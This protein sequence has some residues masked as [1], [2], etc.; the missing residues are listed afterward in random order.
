[1]ALYPKSYVFPLALTD[2][3]KQQ[4]TTKTREKLTEML[5]VEVD[6]VMAEYV[7]VMVGNK[8]NMEQ[9]AHDL[10]DFI[11]E[12]SADQFAAWLSLLLPTFEAQAPEAVD[13]TEQPQA[14]EEASVEEKQ[15]D[16]EAPPK[17]VVSLKGLSSS[18]S[19]PSKTKTVSLSSNRGTIRS[20]NPSKTDTDDVI[21]R[22]AQRFGIVEKKP[23][24]KKSPSSASGKEDRRQRDESRSTGSK[25]RASERESGNR[26]SQRLGPP[27]NVD[28]AELDARDTMGSHKKRRND[29]DRDHDRDRDR[30][31]ENQRG[32][33][34]NN[35]R[36]DRDRDHDMEDAG[37]GGRKRNSD[38][39]DVQP[40]LPPSDDKGDKRDYGR[41]MGPLMG[42]Q[43]GPMGYGGFPPPYGG[44]MF[45]PPPGY[46]PMNP[47]AM[48]FPPQGMPPYGGRGYP[49]GPA[50]GM[51]NGP[52]GARPFQNRKWVN[53]N[54]AKAEE[55]KANEGK[56]GSDAAEGEGS[57][58]T[59]NAGLNAGAPAFAPRNPFFSSQMRPRFQ[60]KTWVRQDPAKDEDLNSSLPKT[61]P[62]ELLES[63]E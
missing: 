27:V 16:V 38:S 28:Q 19:D 40:P 56:T 39:R 47:Y 36:S 48:G 45:Y 63:T 8:K 32:G 60:N 14:E 24:A 29:R 26:L 31:D 37:R 13:E 42:F 62:Q 30:G 53:P 4:I 35:R 50:G 46:G 59:Q 58:A 12:E 6:N 22:R 57:G 11:G 61:P 10:V 3:W 54:V 2:A 7:I 17:R 9:I 43:G 23:A 52:P 49:R 1:M 55:A 41:G 21:A 25:R 15:Q 44:P 51:H 33:G 5:G 34:R 20:L 18:T